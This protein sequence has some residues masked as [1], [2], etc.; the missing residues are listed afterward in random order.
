MFFKNKLKNF[1]KELCTTP[2]NELF[3]LSI[4]TCR[5]EMAKIFWQQGDV[6]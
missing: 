1:F 2:A 4:L 6:S 3:L 5:I